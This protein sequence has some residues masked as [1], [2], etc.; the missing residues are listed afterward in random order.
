MTTLTR[1]NDLPRR[2]TMSGHDVVRWWTSLDPEEYADAEAGVSTYRSWRNGARAYGGSVYCEGPVLFNYGSHFRLAVFAGSRRGEKYY[3][4]NGD[5]HPGPGG[6][7]PST[8]SLTGDVQRQCPHGITVSFSALSAAGVDPESVRF[9]GVFR[10]R[11]EIAPDEAVVLDSWDD[12]RTDL[13]RLKDED[14]HVTYYRST[15]AGN[16][17]YAPWTPPAHGMFVDYHH[18]EAVRELP[19]GP[20]KTTL[21]YWHVLGSALIRAPRPGG[22]KPRYLLCSL[23]EH[24]YFVSE[25]S[26]P[27]R[28][29][30]EAFEKLKPKKVRAAEAAGTRVRRQGEWFFIPT[31]LDDAGMAAALGMTKTA[32]ARRLAHDAAIPDDRRKTNRHHATL[33]LTKDAVYARGL[34]THKTAFHGLLTHEHVS[35]KL[36]GQWHEA[37]KNTE[38]QSWAMSGHF[39]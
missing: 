4:R 14:G 11:G 3:V 36:G 15:H 33:F 34:V 32:F 25:L 5:R 12:R 20:A 1:T 22:G 35:L 7:G 38:A 30:A 10:G 31:G 8:S 26:S 39:D 19:T 13:V 27:A 17:A 23:D 6:F 24:R 29:V 16:D 9:P 18:G 37:V 21:G 2:R 28:T